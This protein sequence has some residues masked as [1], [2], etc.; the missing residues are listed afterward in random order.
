M[1]NVWRSRDAVLLFQDHDAITV[2]YPE[3]QEDEIIPK[4]LAHLNVP[5]ELAYGRTLIVPF[6]CKTG[7]NKGEY[8]AEKNPDGLKSYRP[9]DKR[10]RSPEVSILDRIIR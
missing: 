10:K 9:G 2:Q 6:G 4:I 3:E 7:W 5:V 1:L 8:H